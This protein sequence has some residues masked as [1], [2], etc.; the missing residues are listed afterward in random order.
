MFTARKHMFMGRELMF[1]DREPNFS[2]Y[3][4]NSFC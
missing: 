4:E 1:I 3:K 2:R